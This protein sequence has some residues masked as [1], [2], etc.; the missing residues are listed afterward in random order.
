M[1]K[2]APEI[3][4]KLIDEGNVSAELFGRPVYLKSIKFDVFRRDNMTC[5]NCGDVATHFALARLDDGRWTLRPYGRRHDMDLRFTIDHILPKSRGG[6]DCLSNYQMQCHICNWTKAN[7]LPGEDQKKQLRR[8]LA[9]GY[10]SDWRRV[11]NKLRQWNVKNA[12]AFQGAVRK[13]GRQRDDTT[14][15]YFLDRK[16]I[17]VTFSGGRMVAVSDKVRNQ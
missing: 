2:I 4:F 9:P 11:E 16:P 6:R 8:S 5:Q 1:L 12:H 14:W 7:C 3:V 17:Y 10:V 15:L 13:Y